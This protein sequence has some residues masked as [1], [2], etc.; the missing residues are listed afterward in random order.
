MT[1]TA[2][3]HV[4]FPATASKASGAFIDTGT[5][6]KSA[7]DLGF[8]PNYVGVLSGI[9]LYEWFDG[10]ADDT[11]IKTNGADGVRSVLSSGGITV[12]GDALPVSTGGTAKDGTQNLGVAG[13]WTVYPKTVANPSAAI[14]EDAVHVNADQ[15]L[16]KGFTIAAA[17]IASSNQCYFKASA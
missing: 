7:F 1:I 9:D 17:L 3:I 2:T 6:K 15:E 12:L 14:L 5:V 13:A 11:A 8:V 4:S 16:I 10:M